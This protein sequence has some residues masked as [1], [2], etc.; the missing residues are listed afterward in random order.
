MNHPT[1]CISSI[2]KEPHNITGFEEPLGAVEIE[3]LFQQGKSMSPLGHGGKH[4]MEK[5]KY[6]LYVR[7]PRS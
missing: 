7:T 3:D 2:V 5:S 1:V 6:H 4:D